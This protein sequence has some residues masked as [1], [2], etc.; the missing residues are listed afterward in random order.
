MKINELQIDGSIKEQ[1]KEKL[2][3]H[4]VGEKNSDPYESSEE[5]EDPKIH[6]LLFEESSDETDNNSKEEWECN[7]CKAILNMNDLC[8]NVLTIEENLIL[9]VIDKIENREEKY[10]ALEDYI[11]I[12]KEIDQPRM[13]RNHEE[14]S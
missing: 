3:M 2:L 7:H 8:I 11:C 10:K 6:Q 1:I 13:Q 14:K 9:K 5:E 12:A 4:S